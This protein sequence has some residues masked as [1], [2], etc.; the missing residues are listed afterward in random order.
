MRDSPALAVAQALHDL[1][2]IVTTIDPKRLATRTTS[3][4]VI[5]ARGTLNT[6]QPVVRSRLDAPNARPPLS[7][8]PPRGRDQAFALV[9]AQC[10]SFAAGRQGR[11]GLNSRQSRE[12]GAA[13]TEK[14]PAYGHLR[15][16]ADKTSPTDWPGASMPRPPLNLTIPW[17]DPLANAWTRGRSPLCRRLP[18]Q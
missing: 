18:F 1:G 4:K 8:S 5:D 12:T 9:T 7:P 3:P 2:A 10:S 13:R 16:L 15:Q 6:S 17:S 11:K 14:V